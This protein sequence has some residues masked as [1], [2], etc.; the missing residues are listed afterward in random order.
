MFTKNRVLKI[1]QIDFLLDY[2]RI[3]QLPINLF[4]SRLK[5]VTRRFSIMNFQMLSHTLLICCNGTT[6]KLL[7]FAY[8]RNRKYKEYKNVF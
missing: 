7:F 4:D 5:E 1:M 2:Q 8:K 6:Q 3:R